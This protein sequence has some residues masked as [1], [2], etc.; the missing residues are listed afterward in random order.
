MFM[1]SDVKTHIWYVFYVTGGEMKSVYYI[2]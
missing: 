1:F 2:L